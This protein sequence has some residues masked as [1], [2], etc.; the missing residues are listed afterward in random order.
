MSR[1]S[2]NSPTAT[3]Y[4]ELAC[5]RLERRQMLAGDVSVNVTGSGN[6]VINGDNAD[7]QIRIDA[8]NAGGHVWV[9]GEDGTTIDGLGAYLINGDGTGTIEGNLTIRLKGGADR[10]LIREVHVEGNVRAIMGSDNDSFMMSRAFVDGNVN[11]TTAQGNDLVQVVRSMVHGKLTI[12]TAAGVDRVLIGLA[13]DIDGRTLINT[14]SNHDFVFI[15]SEFDGRLT[16]NTGSGD[17]RVALH[18]MDIVEPFN[19]NL[20]SGSDVLLVH[21]LA[22]FSQLNV[23]GG[24]GFDTLATSVAM[25]NI[26]KASVEDHVIAGLF[27]FTIHDFGQTIVEHYIDVWGGSILDYS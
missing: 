15:N 17:D 20:G 10:A 11:V 12:N 2:N 19:V 8:S 18:A 16:I 7:N 25:M 13:S 26:E 27:D 21:S 3:Q 24:G 23:N 5:E 9:Y 22:S 4:L 6:V 14:G 1:F